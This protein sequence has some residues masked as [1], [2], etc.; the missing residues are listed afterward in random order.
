ME[1]IL[2]K[3][4]SITPSKLAAGTEGKHKFPPAKTIDLKLQHRGYLAHA[5]QSILKSHNKKVTGSEIG[6]ESLDGSFAFFENLSA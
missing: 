4:P 1:D 2:T 5:K 6:P 3:N